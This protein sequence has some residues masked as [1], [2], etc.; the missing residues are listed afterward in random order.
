MEIP[1]EMIHDDYRPDLKKER[2]NVSGDELVPGMLVLVQSPDKRPYGGENLLAMSANQRSR[3]MHAA[4]WR[5]VIQVTLN[6][7]SDIARNGEL[8]YVVGKYSDGSKYRRAYP[9]TE[10]WIVKL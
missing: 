10:L 7:D 8:I 2:T 9:R 4:R 5:K 3:V 6:S 1:S